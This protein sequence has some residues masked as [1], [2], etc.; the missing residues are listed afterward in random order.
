MSKAAVIFDVKGG[1]GGYTVRRW[2]V[3]LPVYPIRRYVE[4]G[5]IG[6][7]ATYDEADKAAKKATREYKKSLGKPVAP[8]RTVT[9]YEERGNYGDT[10]LFLDCGHVVYRKGGWYYSEADHQRK[11]HRGEHFDPTAERKPSESTSHRA[12]CEKCL[13][14]G[15]LGGIATN[16]GE[17]LKV[18]AKHQGTVIVEYDTDNGYTVGLPDGS[19]EFA[20]NKKDVEKIAK[21]WSKAHIPA[22]YNAG[23]LEIDYR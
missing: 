1:G 9:S 5:T 4:V 16:P 8:W 10:R 3:V 7:F 20:L 21:K 2:E 23:M 11:I 12:R 22:G 6:K 19:V 14:E 17:R 15:R 13:A 18:K